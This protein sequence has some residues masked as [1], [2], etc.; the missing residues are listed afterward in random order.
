MHV[1]LKLSLPFLLIAACVSKPHNNPT[2]NATEVNVQKPRSVPGQFKDH[3]YDGKAELSTYQLSQQRYGEIRTGHATL[4]YVTEQFISDKQ[5]KAD[6][7]S[8]NNIDVLKLNSTK[9]FTTGIY[10]YSIMNS[11]FT[12]IDINDHALKVTFSCQE[13]CGHTYIQLNHRENFDL[14][15]HSYFEKLA[16]QSSQLAPAFLEN[17]LWN[18]IR[19]APDS[20]PVGQFQMI[21]ALESA[22]L[23]HIPLKAYNAT[24]KIQDKDSSIEYQLL[25]PD[26]G[27]EIKLTFAKAFPHIIESWEEGVTRMGEKRVSK[28]VRLSTKRLDYW[29]KNT[30][31]D[32]HYRDSLLLNK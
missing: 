26:L 27:R 5:V 19:I 29:N 12:P 1:S 2:A 16:D 11:L 10:P 15:I 4:I 30:N 13:W 17:D 23:Y 8:E 18:L 24:A 28:A 3:W 9:K 6:T 14:E 25:Y 20:L 32:T 7:E 31:A 22:G 21:P